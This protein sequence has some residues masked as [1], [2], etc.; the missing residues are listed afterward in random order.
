MLATTT[1]LR[2]FGGVLRMRENNDG[3]ET[4]PPRRPQPEFGALT[5]VHRYEPTREAAVV[6]RH[7]PSSRRVRSVE[8]Q[9]E[10]EHESRDSHRRYE[11][12]RNPQ[13]PARSFS[14]EAAGEGRFRIIVEFV[15]ERH[16]T[17]PWDQRY[18]AALAAHS[19]RPSPSGGTTETGDHAA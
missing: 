16:Y 8:R 1:A 5:L 2:R 12:K 10:T 3:P 19:I 4:G 17:S 6:D 9:R 13:L 18:T 11:N 14:I 7:R 15:N